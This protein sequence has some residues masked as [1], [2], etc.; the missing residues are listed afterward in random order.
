MRLG[1]GTWCFP[2]SIGIPGQT[3][4]EN[5]LNA[6][7][8][9]EMAKE[10]NLSLVQICDNLPYNEM[11]E[12]ELIEIRRVAEEMGISLALGTRGVQPDHLLNTL[13]FARLLGAN[14]LRTVLDSPDPEVVFDQLQQ[15]LPQFAE[16]GVAIVLE[17]GEIMKT[18]QLAEVVARR[19]S[20]YLGVV[21]DTANS[22]GRP[23]P[24]E[25]VVENLMPYALMIHYKDYTI[26]RIEQAP[27]VFKMGF[28]VLGAPAGEGHIDCDWLFDQIESRGNDPEIV[29]EQWP[30]LLDT[31]EETV[32]SERNWVEKSVRFLQSRLDAR[33][34]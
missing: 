4:P 13:E 2:W 16:A 7:K 3:Q 27:P 20:P 22:L 23:E 25:Q 28:Q 19:D 33:N 12:S 32:A 15:V 17:N 10:W 5:P 29:I 21:L 30:P 34:T 18:A 14:S 6:R 26:S 11:P 9:I 8:L 31:M 24:L 1:I